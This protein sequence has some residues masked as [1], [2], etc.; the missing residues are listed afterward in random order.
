LEIGEIGEIRAA[1]LDLE[2]PSYVGI[3]EATLNGM[4]ILGR[5][6]VLVVETM[7]LDPMVD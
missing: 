5:V 7:V 4:R 1:G 2:K 3:E 6:A